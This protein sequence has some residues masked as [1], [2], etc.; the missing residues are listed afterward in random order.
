MTKAQMRL[1]L[2]V[3][4]IGTWDWLVKENRVQWNDNHFRLLGYEPNAFEPTF[5]RWRAAVHPE[6]LPRVER[7]LAQALKDHSDFLEEYRVIH[8]DGSVHWLLGKGR[9]I[10]DRHGQIVRMAG[11]MFDITERKNIAESLRRSEAL[12]HQILEAIP[13]LLMWLSADGTCIGYAGGTGTH[14]LHTP[15]QAIGC[16]PSDLL[17]PPLLQ[18]S[19]W[20]PWR[21]L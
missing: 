8:A 12:N 6:D 2:D 16:K 4:L 9:G 10:L 1:A 20:L 3:T 14:A 17:P 7:A 13:D 11:V 21:Q 15:A 5:E 19:V 18:T